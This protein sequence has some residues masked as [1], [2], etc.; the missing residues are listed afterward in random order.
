MN[1]QI[2][3]ER[4]QEGSWFLPAL[5]RVSVLGGLLLWSAAGCSRPPQAD[6]PQATVER[7][8]ERMRAGEWEDAAE[9]ATA[10]FAEYL[11]SVGGVEQAR[12][13][14]LAAGRQRFGPS[15]DEALANI[16]TPP[17]LPENGPAIADVTINDERAIVA[18]EGAPDT[19]VSTGRVELVHQDGRW[20]VVGPDSE[21]YTRLQVAENQQRVAVLKEGARELEVGAYVSAAHAAKWI[22]GRPMRVTDNQTPLI[23]LDGRAVYRAHVDR[24]NFLLQ[25]VRAM[26]GP[27][28]L[29]NNLVWF[30]LEEECDRASI[31]VAEQ[32][33][34]Q[35][36][37]AL[38]GPEAEEAIQRAAKNRGVSVAQFERD[39]REGITLVLRVARLVERRAEE[40]ANDAEL[41]ESLKPR[42]HAKVRIT[43]VRAEPLLDQMPAPSPDEIKAHYERYAD[44][45]TPLVDPDP[46]HYGYQRPTRYILEYVAA[47]PSDFA[48][49]QDVSEQVAY[50]Y[51]ERHREQFTRTNVDAP[52]EAPKPTFD[53]VREHVLAAVRQRRAWERAR[54]RIH[55]LCGRYMDR[56]AAAESKG[57]PPAHPSF[58]AAL[59]DDLQCD[60][61]PVVQTEALT[62]E[63]FED[64]VGRVWTL[65]H[66][67]VPL[68]TVVAA[69]A[70]DCAAPTESEQIA[71]MLGAEIPLA[72]QLE[73]AV[74]LGR[75]PA[76][77][78]AEP[79]APVL[80]VRLV[81]TLPP[82]TP[83]LADVRAPIESDLR[84][85][86]AMAAASELAQRLLA[87]ARED[88]D[89]T[90][91]VT[92][93][94]QADP[95]RAPA[96]TSV[97]ETVVM[98]GGFPPRVADAVFALPASAESGAG[99]TVCVADWYRK[100]YSVVELLRVE[101]AAESEGAE[102]VRIQT[103]QRMAFFDLT[104][105]EKMAERL[106]LALPPGP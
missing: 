100:C 67:R 57:A 106:N 73:P 91:A 81:R 90:A 60:G 82:E 59:A 95:E 24:V 6:T 2:W 101:D 21:K 31:A 30:L 41:V 33:V 23:L 84:L 15:A 25:L 70:E 16:A 35:S 8:L 61:L 18:L 47:H 56:T 72:E 38:C 64:R 105:P 13:Q 89:L 37:A 66:S 17:E 34:E 54:G 102:H 49:A 71:R 79:A 5:V 19:E 3:I 50:A 75:E 12:Q 27:A 86:A 14:L 99:R 87:V 78:A 39:V 53:A 28:I 45:P 48:A 97:R 52:T 22:R 65:D 11:R 77:A 36:W 80:L 76:P 7:L 10:P 4:W 26:G 42:P 83:A 104:S 98:R 58:A 68:P 20:R 96:I 32:A 1:D 94:Q 51:Y 92:H 63:E 46:D 43:D 74:V 44:S 29:E 88:K 103:L 40:L 93:L 85:R 9:L 55:D 69:L 62:P